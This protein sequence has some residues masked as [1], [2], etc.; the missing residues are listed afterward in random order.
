M[1]CASWDVGEGVG[2]QPKKVHTC[3]YRLCAI[4]VPL[5]MKRLKYVQ[6]DS[7]FEVQAL[8]WSRRRPNLRTPMNH[9][10]KHTATKFGFIESLFKPLRAELHRLS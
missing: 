9:L 7:G 4:A 10:V 2:R 8:Q 1:A 6:K 3:V 5:L